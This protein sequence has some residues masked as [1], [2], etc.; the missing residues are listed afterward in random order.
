MTAKRSS[1]NQRL[2]INKTLTVKNIY[3]YIYYVYL[4]KITFKNST[5]G[6]KKTNRKVLSIRV[7][8]ENEAELKDIVREKDKELTK[9]KSK[10]ND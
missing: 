2:E 6:R 4:L 3:V 1:G 10:R 8:P 5:M 9:K 7:D